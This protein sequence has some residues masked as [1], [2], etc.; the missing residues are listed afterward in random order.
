MMNV[1]IAVMNLTM[2]IAILAG[3]IVLSEMARKHTYK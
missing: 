3:M 2:S 1:L